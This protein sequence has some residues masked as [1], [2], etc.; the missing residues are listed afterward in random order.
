MLAA[1]FS[2]LLLYLGCLVIGPL[3]A[4]VLIVSLVGS[5]LVLSQLITPICRH[6]PRQKL[7]LEARYGHILLE[8]LGSIRDI[9][10][11]PVSEAFF[12]KGVH[13]NR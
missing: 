10:T 3:A 8:S 6:A 2:I 9:Q 5:Y 1:F 13:R 12:R 7:R 4:V 11:S